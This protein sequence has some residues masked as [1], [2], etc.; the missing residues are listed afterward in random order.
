MHHGKTTRRKPRR[1]AC[2]NRKRPRTGRIQSR[3]KETPETEQHHERDGGKAMEEDQSRDSLRQLTDTPRQR[4]GRGSKKITNRKHAARGRR[5]PAPI[6]PTEIS[7]QTEKNTSAVSAQYQKS[8]KNEENQAN[9]K[10]AT[11]ETKYR[12]GRRRPPTQRPERYRTSDDR[13]KHS[14]S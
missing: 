8:A 10:D 14:P 1:T 6:N 12:Q 13:R 9:R 3:T 2:I 11:G 4:Q 5:R 7:E